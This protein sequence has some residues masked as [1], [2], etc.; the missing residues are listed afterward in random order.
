MEIIL[1]KKS[2]VK[3]MVKK[4]YIVFN[5]IIVGNMFLGY[6]SIIELIKNN[7]NMVIWFILFVMVCDGLDG[8]IVRK[9]DVFSE[10]GKEFDLFCDVVLFGLVLLMLIYL[11]LIKNVLGSLFIVLV[12]FLYVFCGVMRLVKFNIINVVLSEKGDFS[13]MFI[14]NVVVMVVFYIMIC[15]VLEIIF[16]LIIFNIRVF[17]V[18]L[19]ILVGLMVSIMLFKIFDKI[20]LFIFK[21]L[22][23]IIIL[24]FLIFMYWIL[25][26]SV[27]IIFYIYVLLNIFIYFYKR[28]GSEEE[29]DED[30]LI[31][32]FIEVDENEEKGE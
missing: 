27:F 3:K 11:I 18:I 9:L 31:E 14:F 26:Y 19:V 32:E 16:G 17:I 21:K 12:L 25:N 28:F 24:G 4:K 30:E 6:L 20:F 22:V 23:L 7:F 8:K 1:F 29:K 13:G 5:F 10:F 15:N 2:E